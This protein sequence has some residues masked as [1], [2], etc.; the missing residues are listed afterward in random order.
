MFFNKKRLMKINIILSLSLMIMA[1]TQCVPTAPNEMSELKMDSSGRDPAG[2]NSLNAFKNTVYK[3]TSNRCS[4]CHTTQSPTHAHPDAGT[5]HDIVEARL[6]RFDNIPISRL[7]DKL[8]NDLHN[9]W[10]N[11]EQNASEMEKAIEDWKEVRER[12]EGTDLGNDDVTCV[13]EEVEEEIYNEGDSVAAFQNSVWN[14]TRTNC[15]SCHQEG[16]VAPTKHAHTNPEI[17]HDA[18][19]DGGFISF[20]NAADSE[21]VQKISGGHQG[22]QA[23]TNQLISEI[24][25]WAANRGN[26]EVV[27]RVVRRCGGDATP[28]DSTV[29]D[30]I[31]G[32]SQ[33]N[34]KIGGPT[35]LDINQA[36]IINNNFQIFGSGAQA[37]LMAQTGSST[38]AVN[39]NLGYA[40][41]N[42]AVDLAGDYKIA[43]DIISPSSAEDS[44]W[45]SVDNETP[46]QWHTGIFTTYN[47]VVVTQNAGMNNKTWNLGVGNHTLH[48]RQREPNVRIKGITVYNESDSGAALPAGTGLIDF[49]IA[50]LSGVPGARIQAYIQEFDDYSYKLWG[51][52]VISNENIYIKGVKPLING[53]Y[54]PNNSIFTI[55]DKVVGPNDSEVSPYSLLML[56]ENGADS[57]RIQFQFDIIEKE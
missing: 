1:F 21:I 15:T 10:G 19:L 28:T 20:S 18:L 14:F 52:R 16:G 22:K 38:G 54:S 56:K 29:A 11:C 35:D 46:F 24:Q 9:C 55:V 34:A 41:L 5:A 33:G 48:I 13:D 17:A 8:R 31:S 49:D 47:R 4:G 51:L 53:Y 40:T 26:V 43:A 32:N 37:Y 42:F 39:N 23:L 2:E 7:V 6:V 44:F 36:N 25:A 45:L 50:D 30:I 27:T 57:D 3:I 12:S